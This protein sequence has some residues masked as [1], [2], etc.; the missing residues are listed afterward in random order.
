MRITQTT[1]GLRVH[2]IAGT[3]VV[4]LGFNLPEAECNG[5]LGFSIHART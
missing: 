4:L 3:Y 2:A 1:N 5:L